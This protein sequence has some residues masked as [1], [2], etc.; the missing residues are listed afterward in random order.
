MLWSPDSQRNAAI[1]QLIFKSVAISE[2]LILQLKLQT[3]LRFYSD[4]QMQKFRY[5]IKLIICFLQ[6]V[7]HLFSVKNRKSSFQKQKKQN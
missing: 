3:L 4:H 1:Q 5:K 6:R 2:E 7:H